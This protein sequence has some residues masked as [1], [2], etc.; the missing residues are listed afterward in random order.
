MT[1]GEGCDTF[2]FN[3]TSIG[4]STIKDY[5]VGYDIIEF[6]DRI[7]IGS[8][9]VKFGDVLLSL[10]NGGTINIKY[11][12]GQKITFSDEYGKITTRTFS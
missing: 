6:D 2:L 1:G 3:K 10:T 9:S 12:A 5:Q 4:N 8:S 11:S 7:G